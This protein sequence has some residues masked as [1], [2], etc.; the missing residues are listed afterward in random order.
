MDIDRRLRALA[1]W[2]SVDDSI[3]VRRQ[4]GRVIGWL[5]ILGSI[6][7]WITFVG[8]PNWSDLDHALAAFLTGAGVL[9]GVALVVWAH[10]VS[11][12]VGYLV[13]ALSIGAV[14]SNQILVGA[15]QPV[16]VAVA[17]I[18]VWVAVLAAIYFRP[19]P[20]AA[21]IVLIT[22]MEIAGLVG[23][24]SHAWLPQ[25]IFT[26]G[27][28]GTV[29]AVVGGLAARLRRLTITDPLTGVANRRKFESVLDSAIATATQRGRNLTVLLVDLDDFKVLNDTRGHVAGD[30]ALV[31]ATHAWQGCLRHVDT[32]ARIGGDEFAV[33][34]PG[35]DGAEGMTIA[36]RL[37]AVTPP[38][39]S[40]SIG[41]APLDGDGSDQALISRADTAMYAAKAGGGGRAVL[42]AVGG[43]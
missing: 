23:A 20:V 26:V 27:T 8:L 17:M 15:A 13:F 32:L 21:L 28:C 10:R 36:E 5:Y 22:V 16:G 24:N 2:L 39:L 12:P 4:R 19:I 35:C 1:A 33:V 3:P 34:L 40:C 30:E 7:G 14:A 9:V 18:Y 29:A 42:A 41:V 25:V 37:L 6:L 11:A 38:A 31:A 43:R